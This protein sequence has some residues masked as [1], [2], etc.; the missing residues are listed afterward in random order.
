MNLK[1][2]SLLII[3][4]LVGVLVFV[5]FNQNEKKTIDNRWYTK[6]QLSLGKDVFL[7]NCA[8]CHGTKAEKTVDWKK[9]LSD[10]SYPPPPLNENAHAWHHPK[11]QLMQIITNGGAP[12]DGKMPAFKDTLTEEEKEA[13]ISYFQSFW[14]D[15]IYKIWLDSREGLKDK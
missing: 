14:S 12:Y 15:K 5:N 6:E 3:L 1:K 9:T 2:I 8:S 4:V 10:G 13:T 7:K 11:W